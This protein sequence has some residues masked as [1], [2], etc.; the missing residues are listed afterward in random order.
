[1][2]R[3]TR[4]VF[5]ILFFAAPYICAVT[6][7]PLYAD[8]LLYEFGPKT[9][10]ALIFTASAGEENQANTATLQ[11][12]DFAKKLSSHE[13]AMRIIIAI[14][15][16]DISELP[17]DIPVKRYEGTKQLIRE[18]SAYSNPVVCL[19]AP[20]NPQRVQLIAGTK[21][22]APPSWFLQSAY[23]SLRSEHI[24][25]DFYSYTVLLH[26][27]GWLPDDPVLALYAAAHMPVLKLETNVDLSAFFD[28]F[29]KAVNAQ[30]DKIWDSH[31]FI[32]K[33]GD[34]LVIIGEKLMVRILI[35]S[36]MLILLWLIMFSFLFG[37][38]RAQHVKDLFVLWWMPIYFFSVNYTGFYLSTQIT[39][40]LFYLR[41][42]AAYE[43][44]T[45]P[46][47]ALAVKYGFVLFFIFAFT[48]FNKLI[49]LPA[50][51]F[52]YGFMANTVCLI[53]IFIFSVINLSFSI[54]FLEIYIISVIAYRSKNS[55]VQLCSIGALLLPLAPFISYI[56]TYQ[57]IMFDSAFAAMTAPSFILVPFDLLL[58]RLGL[59]LDKKRKQ[60]ETPR[61]HRFKIPLQ[62]VVSGVVFCV[63]M[64]WVFF[65]P[66]SRRQTQHDFILVQKITDDGQTVFKKYG[67]IQQEEPVASVI[68]K[69]DDTEDGM[70]DR[71]LTVETNLNNYF[72]RSIGQIVIR[73]AVKAE[74][75]SVKIQADNDI[76]VFEADLPFEQNSSGDTA[77][78]VSIPRPQFPFAVHF[79]GKKT[80]DL[81]VTVTLWSKENPFGIALPPA[82]R[83]ER[84]PLFLLKLQK[85]VRLT[86]AEDAPV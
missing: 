64:L 1:M 78:F 48:A 9:G 76:A 27:L 74:A 82:E 63:L 80:A 32:R 83:R 19:I 73:P 4:S 34:S 39:K 52:I 68:R 43:M 26:K 35:V 45:F 51:R 6:V 18:L 84:E 7:F 67:S 72:E 25:V 81:T 54:T 75:V 20:G 11:L 46:L 17:P 58:I 29:S 71:L 41:F 47:T 56:I 33:A 66:V 77:V 65:M 60:M 28:T 36:S 55:I 13:P 69:H 14:T 59:S 85:I 3:F 22:I 44:Q 10:T 37:K 53:N 50:N 5:R 21:G 38:K 23:R 70:I 57:S 79:S 31:Y 49:P 24:P 2:S 62:C 40:A 30:D 12:Q 61:P 42:S 8:N 15:K 16:N 86:A